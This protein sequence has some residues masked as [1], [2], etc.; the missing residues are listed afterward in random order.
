MDFMGIG[1]E[2]I[3]GFRNGREGWQESCQGK[4]GVRPL[5]AKDVPRHNEVLAVPKRW[6]G[7]PGE[8][9]SLSRHNRLFFFCVVSF[10]SPAALSCNSSSSASML[11]SAGTRA[12][13]ICA[14]GHAMIQ[15]GCGTSKSKCGKMVA[16]GGPRCISS[17]VRLFV[18]SPVGRKNS[19]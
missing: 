18:L 17:Q 12:R 11:R 13:H 15:K 19:S 8:A 4:G 5:Q 6:D 10:E 1:D 3:T 2:N 9:I 14:I 7:D 16:M